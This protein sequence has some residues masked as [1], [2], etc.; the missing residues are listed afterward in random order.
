MT[1]NFGLNTLEDLYNRIRPALSSKVSELRLH[2]KTY[3]KEEDIWNY[4]SENDWKQSTC[5]SLAEMISDIFSLKE[6]EICN[7]VLNTFKDEKR[8]IIKDNTELL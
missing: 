3:I 1:E 5:L 2:G 4:L 6:E 7:Y 8:Q